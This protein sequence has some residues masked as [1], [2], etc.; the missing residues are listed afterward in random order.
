MSGDDP[1]CGCDGAPPRPVRPD[2][3]PGLARIAYRAIRHGESVARMLAALP[4]AEVPD[5]RAEGAPHRP[6]A[7]L[8]T[9]APDDPAIGLIDA[10]AVALDALSLQ[11]ERIAQ[12]TFLGTATE[13]LSVRELARA[14]GYELAPGLAAETRLAFTVEDADDPHRAV[15]VPAGTQAMS[16]PARQDERPQVF[17]TLEELL[18]RA[19]FNAIPAR[20]ERPQVLALHHPPGAADP[21]LVLIDTD[22]SFALGAIDPAARRDVREA[23]RA[24]F[25][26]LDPGLDLARVIAERAADTGRARAEVVLPAI[27]VD[28]IMLRGVATGV[29]PGDRLLA[30]GRSGNAVRALALLVREVE[31]EAAWQATRVVVSPLGTAGGAAVP[32][33][34]PPTVRPSD[35]L[36]FRKPRLADGRVTTT[37]I[38]LTR[39]AVADTL[40]RREFTA[41]DLQ[42]L[43][44]SQAW[45]AGLVAQ[46]LRSP[47]GADAPAL[48]AAAPGIHAFRSRV[49][50][51]GNVA[52]RQETLARPG[53]TRGTDPYRFSWD[54]PPGPDAP[55]P[56][57]QPRPIWQSSQGAPLGPEADV[58]LERA[59]EEIAPDSW[60]LIEAPANG[61]DGAPFVRVLPLRVARASVVS[62]S[63]F[64]LSGKVSALVLNALDGSDLADDSA[65]KPIHFTFRTASAAV[66]SAPLALAGL[67]LREPLRAGET[68]LVLDRL[69]PDLAPGRAVAV[70][71]ERADAPGVRHDE[72]ALLADVRHVGGY[73][74]LVFAS[75]L[76]QA[77]ARQSVTVNANVVR[78]SHGETIEEVLGGGDATRA[79]QAF[80]LKK[81]PLTHLAHDRPPGRRSTLIVRVDG[82]AWQERPF[83]AEA[84]PADRVY[85]VRIDE[86][87]TTRIVFGDGVH[88]ARLP[89]GAMNVRARYRSGSGAAGG[90]AAGSIILLKTRPLGIRSVT[91]PDAAAGWAEPETMEEARRNVPASVRTLG[92]I[93][94]LSDYEHTA[95][96]WPGFG[97]ARAEIVARGAERFVHLTVGLA[98]G[99]P[100]L[101]ADPVLAA[102]VRAIDAM[103][104]GADRVVVQGFRAAPF[105]LAATLEIDPAHSEESVRE[106]A[107]AALEA[108]FGYAAMEF[109]SPVSGA[110]ALAALQAV[111]GVRAVDLDRLDR[112]DDPGATT[113]GHSA[114][115]R[116]APAEV[117]PDGG[118]LPAEL[119]L[120]SPP[121]VALAIE[122]ADAG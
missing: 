75:G 42:A 6:L 44:R 36:T 20:R 15:T 57:G 89:T 45:P 65:A 94:S 76:A 39:E 115:L 26:P 102:L 22:E 2:N 60:I 108:R 119:L 35:R 80:A 114:L 122:V 111:P 19:E 70:R 55:A 78:A 23:N 46:L 100:P 54:S 77:L 62:R 50:F 38:A 56:H 101:A 116:A 84:G 8:T 21:V 34:P 90:V 10:W 4:R 81:P 52:P 92:R 69:V 61:P 96:T 105:G 87:G 71:G 24:Q 48:G 121:H 110:A 18:A 9:R 17:E 5:P 3:R 74:R 40:T 64:A 47:T 28:E 63:D 86:D 117:G 98:S 31:T 99:R 49:G 106:V 104:D 16:V 83:L 12:E 103:R 33:A 43:I 79:N 113:A 91:N 112:L 11:A 95:R 97:K 14:V 30:V 41:A 107:L 7:R 88:G 27:A 1:F 53:E 68:E 73:T 72:I 59:V 109:A 13:R 37:P 85:T 51:F 120:L 118:I 67:P 32:P 82:V 25:F 58:Y 29:R 93:V 66:A